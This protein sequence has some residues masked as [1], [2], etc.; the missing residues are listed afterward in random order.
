MLCQ[1]TAQHNFYFVYSEG[2]PYT[3]AR[4]ITEWEILKRHV[5]AFEEAL[6]SKVHWVR[7]EYRIEMGQRDGGVY[8]DAGRQFMTSQREGLSQ[9]PGYTRHHRV[10]AQGFITHRAQVRQLHEIAWIGGST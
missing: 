2:G 10:E 4:A 5:L 9:F 8:R 6:R 7:I 1:K 3:A